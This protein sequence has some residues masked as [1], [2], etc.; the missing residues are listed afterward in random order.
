MTRHYKQHWDPK[1]DLVFARRLRIGSNPKKPFAM[2][3]EK[4]TKKIREKLGANRLRR[5][6]E[7]GTLEIANFVAPEPQRR[8]AIAQR[9]QRE[10]LAAV[11]PAI[12]SVFDA[13][14]ATLARVNAPEK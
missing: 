9:E 10:K 4:V 11:S 13:N 3:G 7:N 2:P 8:L 1:A 5:W 12:Q 6:F 14:V